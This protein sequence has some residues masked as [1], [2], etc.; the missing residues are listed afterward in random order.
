[1]FGHLGFRA[2]GVFRVFGRLGFRAPGILGLLGCWGC[3]VLGFGFSGFKG[4]WVSIRVIG[5]LRL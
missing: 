5:V 2:L 3:T 1:M 4:F